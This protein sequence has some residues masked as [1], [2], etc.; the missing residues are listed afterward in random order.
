MNNLNRGQ[1]KCPSSL[2]V[3]ITKKECYFV[4][5]RCTIS[6]CF[7]SCFCLHIEH[8]SS[9]SN[10]FAILPYISALFGVPLG[11]YEGITHL[12]LKT[13]PFKFILECRLRVTKVEVSADFCTFQFLEKDCLVRSPFNM[14]QTLSLLQRGNRTLLLLKCT[15]VDT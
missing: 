12:G 8:R 1:L 3:C 11:E 5:Q 9:C 13:G 10:C 15:H 6:L 7:L 2:H 14:E 4:L